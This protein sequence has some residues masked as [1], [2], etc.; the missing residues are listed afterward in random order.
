MKKIIL[1][2]AGYNYFEINPILQNLNENRKFKLVGI[3][4]DD[5]KYYKK[6]LKGIPFHIG[7]E[8]AYKFK[9]HF[10]IFA[11]SSYKITKIREKI[12]KKMNISNTKFPNIIHN[13]VLIEDNVEMGYGNIIYPNSVI[14]SKTK[15]NDFCVLTYSSILAHNVKLNS[16]SVLGSRSTVLNNAKIGK[17]V[18][19]GANVTIGENL[20]IGDNSRLAMGS[21]ITTNINKNKIAIG[22]PAKI[23][24]DKFK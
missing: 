3:L 8:N 18:F 5:K 23:Y 20:K 6:N 10:F 1:V 16:F 17:S 12:F 11:I 14:C 7:L 13:S 15:I 4:D 9:N 2:G 19:V 24:N 22:N 21:V